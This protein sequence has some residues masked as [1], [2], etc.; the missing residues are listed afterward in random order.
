MAGLGDWLQA[1]RQ[2]HEKA[3]RGPLRDQDLEAYRA[4]RDE[5][6]RALLAAQRLALRPGETPRRALRVARAARV[7]RLHVLTLRE[8]EAR[9][10]RNPSWGIR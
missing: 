10:A 8:G 9:V 1:F 2:L 6:A 7:E 4:G 5:L 3:R